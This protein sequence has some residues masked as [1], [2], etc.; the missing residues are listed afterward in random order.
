MNRW[1]KILGLGVVTWAVPFI[2]AIPLYS[3][4]L[5]DPA[6]FKTIMIVSGSLTGMIATVYYLKN[7]KKDVLKEGIAI[8]LIWLPLNWILDILI[9]LPLSQQSIPRYF[10]E[11]GLSYLAIPIMT[12]GVGYAL[13]RK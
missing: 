12:V 8:G 9:L 13:N 5:S 6:F 11:I 3:L 2:L 10:L 4:M 7:I 1:L